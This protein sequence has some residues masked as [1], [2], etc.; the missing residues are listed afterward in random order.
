MELFII[1]SFIFLIIEIC[2]SC[3]IMTNEGTP[4]KD[5]DILE[6]LN[7][8]LDSYDR[9]RENYSC[10]LQIEGGPY[11]ARPIEKNK[12]IFLLFPYTILEVGVVPRWYKSKKVIDKKF[13]ELLDNSKYKSKKRNQLG[14]K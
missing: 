12:W 9:I 1:L 10:N 13:K 11:K 3:I 4:A 14:L 2:F 8:N 6:Y 5:K 7:L